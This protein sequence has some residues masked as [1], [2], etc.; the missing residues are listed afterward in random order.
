MSEDQFVGTEYKGFTLA[1]LIGKG[2]FAAV[3]S[4]RHSEM[5]DVG[6][7]VLKQYHSHPE[8]A[9]K[10]SEAL[11]QLSHP[12]IIKMYNFEMDGY[13][14]KFMLEE[15]DHSLR[16]EMKDMKLEDALDRTG[17]ILTGISYAHSKGFV[18]KDLKPDNVLVKDGV[19]KLTDWNLSKDLEA[20]VNDDVKLSNAKSLSMSMGGTPGY[21]A[22]EG[23]KDKL[24]D[25]YSI[26]AILYEMITGRVP[27][28][29]YKSASQFNNAPKWIDDVI[30]KALAA[31]PQDRYQTAD[32]MLAD[33]KKKSSQ[34]KNLKKITSWHEY[35]NLDP[36]E[37][38]GGWS[39][40]GK[41][42][43]KLPL[44]ILKYGVG[45]PL[46]YTIGLPIV[47]AKTTYD[48]VHEHYCGSD[49]GCPFGATFVGLGL[50]AAMTIGSLIGLNKYGDYDL[51]KELQANPPKGRI[52]FFDPSTNR[53]SFAKAADL[54]LDPAKVTTI[55]QTL[56]N[57][58][59]MAPSNDGKQVYALHT[60]TIGNDSSDRRI[61][62]VNL[63]TGQLELIATSLTASEM[64]GVTA[65]RVLAKEYGE[66]LFAYANKNWFA[67]ADGKLTPLTV[68]PPELNIDTTAQSADGKYKIA[69]DT[70]N[71][72]IERTQGFWSKFADYEIGGVGMNSQFH[73]APEG[74]P[75][76][77][78]PK[79][80]PEPVVPAPEKPQNPANT[81]PGAPVEQ[82]K[83]KSGF[84]QR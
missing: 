84:E 71:L 36:A 61:S 27:L 49:H 56:D 17:Q 33:L 62:R 51:A 73:W 41:Q 6:G 67:V 50:Y 53:V 72:Q 23:A 57:V 22:P 8:L 39:F 43:L 35:W 75:Y 74:N 19:V 32:E 28:G 34:P 47:L 21:T 20:K 44:A 10:E 3:Y 60:K 70:N 16:A 26:G 2:R 82:P 59:A 14:P 4:L 64:Q 11:R 48:S 42:I 5:P 81:F 69:I 18:H 7:F 1:K 31:E 13:T 76:I 12:N 52:V 80:I 83:L 37:T 25:I 40:I 77:Q 9:A 79:A 29:R 78:L 24:S 55:A 68:F 65:F 63:E 46:K 30:D 58:V 38:S 45:M 15:A 66:Q 54:G